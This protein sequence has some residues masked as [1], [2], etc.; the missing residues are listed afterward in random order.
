MKTQSSGRLEIF[1]IKVKT[2]LFNDNNLF[3]KSTDIDQIK[4]A[5]ILIKPKKHKSLRPIKFDIFI[6][7]SWNKSERSNIITYLY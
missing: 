6:D 4:I 3:F 2:Q 1:P 5:I 7:I